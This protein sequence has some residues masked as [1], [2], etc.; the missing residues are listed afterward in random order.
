MQTWFLVDTPAAG[1]TLT[2][3]QASRQRS[4]DTN[5]AED[6]GHLLDQAFA[7][8]EPVLDLTPDAG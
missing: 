6:M 5:G 3:F 2:A 4:A 8:I 7:R 1:V